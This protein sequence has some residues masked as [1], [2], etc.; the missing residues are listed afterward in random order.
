MNFLKSKGQ[1]YIMQFV[2]FFLIGIGLFVGIGNFFRTQYEIARRETADISIEMI[3][4]YFSSL[5]VASF[6]SC[7]QCGSVENNIKINDRTAGYF[8]EFVLNESGLAVETSPPE[9]GHISSLNNLNYSFDYI[10]GSAPSIQTINLTYDRI[11]NK[12]EIK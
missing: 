5:I 4:G 11:Q 7:V 6:R 2:L 3:N 1:S 12:L 9:K 8:L 10:G